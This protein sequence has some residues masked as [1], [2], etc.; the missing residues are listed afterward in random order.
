MGD[1]PRCEL[2]ARQAWPGW[3][4]WG[5]ETGAYQAEAERGADDD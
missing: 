1:V 4:A 2:F 5:D 3:Q